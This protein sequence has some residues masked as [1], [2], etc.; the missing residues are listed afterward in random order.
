M[1]PNSGWVVRLIIIAALGVLTI[2]LVG[3]LASLGA[4]FPVLTLAVLGSPQ[5]AT[6]HLARLMP[7]PRSSEHAFLVITN[8]L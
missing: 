4:H 7:A 5:R 3:F 2:A 8:N 6:S 1:P